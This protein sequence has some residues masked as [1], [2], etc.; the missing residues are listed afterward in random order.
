ME[1]ASWGRGRRLPLHLRGAPQLENLIYCIP[2]PLRCL[3]KECMRGPSSQNNKHA[4]L[5][6]E[7]R[8][9]ILLKWLARFVW[10]FWA[11]PQAPSP[12]IF[13]HNLKQYEIVWIQLPV[14]IDNVLL[15]IM[16]S[17]VMFVY[18]HILW[19]LSPRHACHWHIVLMCCTLCVVCAGERGEGWRLSGS[20]NRDIEMLWSVR[21]MYICVICH[22]T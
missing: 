10:N 2:F 21:N 6:V 18:G 16:G 15:V 22:F 12:D 9:S 11:E 5:G 19:S 3:R 7:V 1:K 17:S 8:T 4:R 14:I 20:L 13:R